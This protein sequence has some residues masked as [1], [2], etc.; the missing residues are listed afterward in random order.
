MRVE[1]SWSKNLKGV[2]SGCWLPSW[3][4]DLASASVGCG[5]S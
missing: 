1:S 3:K 5:R 2:S 4:D